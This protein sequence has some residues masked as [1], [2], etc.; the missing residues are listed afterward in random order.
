M[1]VDAISQRALA[2]QSF[3]GPRLHP[4]GLHGAGVLVRG[5]SCRNRLADDGQTNIDELTLACGPDN[6]LVKP[7]GW[8]ARKRRKR[9]PQNYLLDNND[10]GEPKDAAHHRVRHNDRV[11]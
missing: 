5:A 6:R 10:D 7:G 8:K 3:Q 2:K 4:T 11:T 1:T 9:R